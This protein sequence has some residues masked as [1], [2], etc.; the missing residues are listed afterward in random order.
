MRRIL[1]QVA[2]QSGQRHARHYFRE[3][4]K[5]CVVITLHGQIKEKAS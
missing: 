1:I 5:P 4:Y 2:Y 3:N